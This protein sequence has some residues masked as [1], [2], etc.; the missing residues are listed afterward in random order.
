[1][2]RLNPYLTF[3]TGTRTAMEGYQRIFGGDL[4][5]STFAEYGEEGEGADG[6]M[7]AQLTTPAGYVLMASDTPPGMPS[8]GHDGNVTLSLSGDEEAELRSYWDGL[9][10]GGQVTMPLEPQMWGDT[11]GTLTDRFGTSWMV[12]IAGAP[13]G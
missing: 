2:S 9:A 4:T 13:Q 7:H 1:M 11:F 3:A 6:I 5:M 12:N 10:E 8:P